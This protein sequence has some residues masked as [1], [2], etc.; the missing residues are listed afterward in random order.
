MALLYFFTNPPLK[1]ASAIARRGGKGGGRGG[2]LK[3]GSSVVAKS[4]HF[5][6]SYMRYNKKNANKLSSAQ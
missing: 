2:T 4:L 3:R 6:M 1:A 5:V